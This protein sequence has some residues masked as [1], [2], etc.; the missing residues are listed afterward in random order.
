M[1]GLLNLL[2]GMV[3][4][5]V[6]VLVGYPLETLKTQ[7]QMNPTRTNLTLGKQLRTSLERK[8]SLSLYSGVGTTLIS[9]ALRRSYQFWV[10][11]TLKTDYNPYLA[12]GISGLVG[13][14]ISSPFHLIRT[15]LQLG[16]YPS[17]RE[18]I[19]NI[20]RTEGW[21]GF[22]HGTAIHTVREII[23]S[24]IYLGNYHHLQNHFN[25]EFLP[26]G[27]VNRITNNFLAGSISSLV[28]WGIFFPL[29][30]LEIAVQSG[31]GFNIIHHKVKHH[32]LLNL[33]KGFLPVAIRVVPVSGLSM[34][35]YEQVKTYIK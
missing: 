2:P 8:S 19:K 32:G 17:T 7:M 20:Y 5:V 27:G 24:G 28:T 3:A 11:E 15:R 25:N 16:K 18:C 13:C 9:Q 35:A 21:R 33:W 1:D 30:T 14:P 31:D 22:F 26:N 6:G 23:Y 4:G 10:Y 29:S 34:M 12:G